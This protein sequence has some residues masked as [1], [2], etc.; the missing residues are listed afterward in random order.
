MAMSGMLW[1]RVAD[2]YSWTLRSGSG[3]GLQKGSCWDAM[4]RRVRV[5]Y[6]GIDVHSGRLGGLGL[7]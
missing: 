5:G 4:T 1:K 2:S 7:Y 3:R 6:R